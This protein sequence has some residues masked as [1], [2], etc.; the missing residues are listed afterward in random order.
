MHPSDFLKKNVCK[1]VAWKRKTLYYVY[2]INNFKWINICCSLDKD[3][4][5]YLGGNGS[6][7]NLN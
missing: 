4:H 2:S 7:T 1:N 3:P 5:N 6:T